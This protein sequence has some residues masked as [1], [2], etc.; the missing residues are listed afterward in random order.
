VLLCGHQ[1][2]LSLQQLLLL[3]LGWMHAR[4]G[5]LACWSLQWLLV[6]KHMCMENTLETV[7]DG[8]NQALGHH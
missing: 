2:L 1:M 5:Q 4:R 8:C 7:E 3:R 6:P